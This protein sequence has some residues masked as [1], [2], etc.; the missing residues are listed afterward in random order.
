MWRFLAL[1]TARLFGWKCWSAGNGWIEIHF[2]KKFC[3]DIYDT[4]RMRNYWL[5][6]SLAFSLVSISSHLWLWEKRLDSNYMESMKFGVGIHPWLDASL[7]EL[8]VVDSRRL[9]RNPACRLQQH[10]DRSAFS[11]T[12][13]WWDVILFVWTWLETE[14]RP[15]LVVESDGRSLWYLQSRHSTTLVQDKR[16]ECDRCVC[17]FFRSVHLWICALP[18]ETINHFTVLQHITSIMLVLQFQQNA[19]T[20]AAIASLDVW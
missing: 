9:T 20:A 15:W 11:H 17:V 4:Q 19:Q 2:W 10:A 1:L 14:N 16:C 7:F 18:M 5:K 3:T 13:L 12:Q 8:F 6:P